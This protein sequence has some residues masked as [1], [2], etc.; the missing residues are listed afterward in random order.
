MFRRHRHALAAR[1]AVLLAAGALLFLSLSAQT[2][3]RTPR[4]TDPVIDNTGAL[5]RGEASELRERILRYE[6]ST[7]NQIA[8]LIIPTL[9]G[10]DIRETAIRI[11]EQS[12]LGQQGKDNGILLL[13][14]KDDRKVAIEVGYGLEGAVTDAVCDRIIRNELRPAFRRDDY[15]GGISEA[16]TAL[17]TASQGEFTGGKKRRK[18]SGWIPVVIII[19]VLAVSVAAASRRR[20][21]AISSKGYRRHND[22]WWGGGGIGGGGFGGGG[23][24][25]FGGGG[26]GG[27]GWSVGGG[28]F[29]GGGASGS[30]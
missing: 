15:Y 28:S 4:I 23:F 13:I 5:S 22:W 8:V 19:A 10:G 3:G 16:L 25:S 9:D 17:M 30:W 1:A 12:K 29:G 2:P 26:G 6:D 27:G 21:Y 20:G 14:A 7:S 24:G 11:L 18:S